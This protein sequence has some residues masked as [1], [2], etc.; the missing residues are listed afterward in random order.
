MS[1]TRAS[2]TA[3]DGRIA[4]SGE[5]SVPARI[6]TAPE[7]NDLRPAV[8]AGEERDRALARVATRSEGLDGAKIR[9]KALRPR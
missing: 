7:R 8:L 4:P 1:L 5:E 6:T 9:S 3:A 2:F